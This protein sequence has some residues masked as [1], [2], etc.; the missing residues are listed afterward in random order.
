M[1]GTEWV[2]ELKIGDPVNISYTGDLS[3]NLNMALVISPWNESLIY[4]DGSGTIFLCSSS[5]SYWY[6]INADG[7]AVDGDGVVLAEVPIPRIELEAKLTE[8]I[9]K[10]ENRLD[11]LVIKLGVLADSLFRP[12]DDVARYGSCNHAGFIADKLIESL[13]TLEP[14]TAPHDPEAPRQLIRE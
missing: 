10:L 6:R 5:G 12:A 14:P 11:I 1:P 2:K 7:S 8:R 4:A 9:A 3:V 13:S